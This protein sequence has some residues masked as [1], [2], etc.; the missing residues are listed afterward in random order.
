MDFEKELEEILRRYI[1]MTGDKDQYDSLIRLLV[2]RIM[3]SH[4]RNA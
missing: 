2:I 4:E 3:E 1:P